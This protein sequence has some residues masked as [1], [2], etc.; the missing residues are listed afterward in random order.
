MKLNLFSQIEKKILILYLLTSLSSQ[1]ANAGQAFNKCISYFDGAF[2]SYD[3]LLAFPFT[4]NDD[5]N[6]GKALSI[7]CNKVE[8]TPRLIC[9]GNENVFYCYKLSQ[10]FGSPDLI[11][12]TDLS[13]C[14]GI[15]GDTLING[16]ITTAG[17][18]G[19][20]KDIYS[21]ASYL[22]TITPLNINDGF[23]N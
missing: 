13:H 4:N 10:S 19:G 12:C 7:C 11:F 3:A 20:C 1:R 6:R 9:F 17:G 16:N 18:A 15:V 21:V 22:A 5:I 2:V 14:G 23:P 8:C